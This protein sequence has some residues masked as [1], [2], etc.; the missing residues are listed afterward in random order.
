MVEELIIGAVE[1][2]TAGELVLTAAEAGYVAFAIQ[3]VAAVYTLSDA[4]RKA[5]NAQKIAY[6][7]SFVDRYVMTRG[8]TLPRQLVLGRQRVSGPIFVM[9][10]YGADKEHLVFCVALAAHEIDAVEAVYFNDEQLVIDGSGNVT[11]VNRRDTYSISTSTAAFTLSSAPLTGS[12]TAQATYGTTVVSLGIVSVAGLVVNVNGGTAGTP[13]TVIVSYKPAVSPFAVNT[14]TTLSATGTTDGSGNASVTLPSVPDA[15]T[16]NVTAI[17]GNGSVDSAVSYD[18]TSFSSFVGTALTITGCGLPLQGFSVSYQNA[19]TSSRARIRTHLGAV[20]QVADATMI[21]NLLG[22]W[23]SAH[24]ATGIAYLVVELDYDQNAFPSG[25]PNV[26]AVVRGAKCYDPRTTLTAWTE[27]PALLLRHAATSSLCGRLSTAYINDNS[28]SAAANVCDTSS[29]Y[30][31][32][33]QTYIRAL[34]TAGHVVNT[35]MRPMD[36][37]NDLAAAMCGKWVFVDGLLRAKAGSYVTPLQYP[38]ETWIASGAKVQVQPRA[39]RA[40]VYN[41]VTGKIA[42]QRHDYQV[43]DFP[44]VSA[45]SYIT[46]DGLELPFDVSLAAVTF[47]GQ[48]Q[49]IVAA[50]MRDARQGLRLTMLCNMRAY[51]VE[52]FDTLSVSLARFGWVNKTFEV[53]DIAWTPDGGIQL[54]MKETDSSAWALGTTFADVDPAPNTLLPSPFT[55]PP[56]LGLSASSGTAQLVKLGDGTIISRILTTWT[57]ITDANVLTSGGVE[58]RYGYAGTSESTWQSV[59]A[60]NSQASVYVPDVKDNLIYLIKARAFNALVQGQWS[61]NLSHKVIGKT[62]LPLNVAGFTSV[63]T[64]SGVQFAWTASTETDYAYTELHLESVWNDATVPLFKGTASSWVWAYPS[65]A[66][67]TILAKHVDATGNRSATAASTVIVVDS[68]MDAL[69]KLTTIASDNVLSAGEKPVVILDY[70]KV[71]AEQSGIDAQATSLGITTEA[72]AY[73]NALAALATYLATLTA[74][75]L[76]SNV[77]GD[78]N[79]VGTTFRTTWALVYSTRQTLLNKIAAISATL[80]AWPGVSSVAVTTGQIVVNAVTDYVEQKVAG[81]ISGEFHSG[82]AAQVTLATVSFGPYSVATTIDLTAYADVD[83]GTGNLGATVVSPTTNRVTCHLDD[84]VNGTGIDR[85][86]DPNPNALAAAPVRASFSIPQT[87]ILP[88]STSGSATLKTLQIYLGGPPTYAAP[89]GVVNWRNIGLKAV[90]R[91]R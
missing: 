20:G 49:Q 38:N 35:S 63:L 55:V 28:I 31:V 24:I 58:V 13:G 10:S 59:I 71:S 77:A 19:A 44:R 26:S 7:A 51:A 25:I 37:L 17:T 80:A 66:T 36:V 60:V 47:S 4:Q 33:G 14:V 21:T 85:Y 79:I 78:T 67:Y 73:D 39:N 64:A 12:V 3:A 69:A 54:S 76:W 8:A 84:S 53:Y 88:A 23:T 89:N 46:E 83:V 74:P 9:N 90:V 5:A 42:D 56:V 1:Y 61:T 48:A 22:V 40:D 70:T 72:T 62:A 6:N 82:S 45:A 11:S 68:S 30:V 27:N 91:K 18:I 65:Y 32:A 15:G 87:I 41:V 81:P 50:N 2:L 34:Y 16:L 57:G 86:Q 29:N 52:I 75:T 43:L